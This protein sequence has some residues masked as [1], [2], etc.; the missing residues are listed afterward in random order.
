MIKGHGF[1][2]DNKEVKISSDWVKTDK[3][4]FENWKFC[5][6]EMDGELVH[7]HELDSF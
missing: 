4:F 1:D 2:A 3:D 7:G 6:F 5:K